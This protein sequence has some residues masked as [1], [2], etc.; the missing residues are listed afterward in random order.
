M[1]TH[2]TN[3]EQI[4]ETTVTFTPPSDILTWQCGLDLICCHQV[5]WCATT[6]VHNDNKKLGPVTTDA[7]SMH[8]IM[9]YKGEEHEKLQNN[10]RLNH[11]LAALHTLH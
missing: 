10:S 3:E 8:N 2:L 11:P 6:L 4:E 5:A 9:T 1:R 7:V